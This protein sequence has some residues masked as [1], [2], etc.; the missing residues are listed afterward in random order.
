MILWNRVL[1]G[2]DESEAALNAVRYLAGVLGGS[3]TCKVRLMAVHQPPCQDDPARRDEAAGSDDDARLLLEE[4]LLK[5]YHILVQARLPPENLSTELVE[6]AG[7][8]VGETI[9]AHQRQGGYGTVVVGRRGVS[10]AEEF[11]FG[12]VSSSV[13]R[14]AG[15]CCVWVVA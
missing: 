6:A 3:S 12:S 1:V 14:M 2:L 10:K 15:D 11:L 8:T 4:Q 5:A 13:V 9:M 7:R